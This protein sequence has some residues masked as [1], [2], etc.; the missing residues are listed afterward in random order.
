MEN[1]KWIK[2]NKKCYIA[3]YFKNILSNDA[4]IY[5]H[6]L[7]SEKSKIYMKNLSQDFRQHRYRYSIHKGKNSKIYNI[8]NKYG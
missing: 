1:L 7:I 8:I 2:L 4:G 3:D 5:A 6:R